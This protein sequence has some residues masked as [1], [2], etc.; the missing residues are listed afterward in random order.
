MPF[1]MADR[2][3][4]QCGL[5]KAG[6]VRVGHKVDVH[7]LNLELATEIGAEAYKIISQ[8]RADQFLGEWLFSVAAFE[9]RSDE[10]DYFAACP[11]LEGT[12]R[13]LGWDFAQLCKLR[14]EVF[15][16]L[17]DRWA[18]K[19]AWRRYKV[20]GFTCTFEQ[21]TPAFALAR[22]IKEKY[23]KIVIVFGGANFDGGM[24]EEYLK[25]L[26]FIDYVVVGEGDVS[27]PELVDRIARGADGLDVPGVIGRVDGK[28]ASGGTSVSV[29]NL[30]GLP[31]PIYDEYFATLFQLGRERVIGNQPPLLLFE[32]ARGCWW[33]EK[34]HCTFC[35]LNAN[36]MQFRSKPP[37]RVRDELRRLSARYKIVNFEAVDNIMDLSYLDQLCEPL[38]EQ[39]SDYQIFY[40]VKANLT[41][42]QLRKLARAGITAIQPGIESLNSHVLNLMRKGT[43]KLINVRLLKWAHYYGI[44]VGWN[45]L[46]GFP[47][48]L[49]EDYEEQVEVLKQIVH[50]PPPAGC[51][52]IWLERFSPY[53]FDPSFQAKNIKP[54]AAYNFIYLESEIDLKKIA[55]FFDHEFEEPRL[56]EQHQKLNDVVCDWKSRWDRGSAPVL[57]YQRAPDWIQVIDRRL[58]Q[59][60]VHAFNCREAFIYDF[61]GETYH[62]VEMIRN[63][64]R[65]ADGDN[66]TT[67]EV[68]SVLER[69]CELGL[70][71]EENGN[72]LSLALP[73]NPNW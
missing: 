8:L 59:P 31:D 30:D 55:Y 9:H 3:S 26:P 32:T 69:F 25:A 44:R 24:G 48:E 62:P 45:I 70:M 21:N 60:A 23:P 68:A 20:V 33:G 73:V 65:E 51:G 12:C 35:G 66:A 63:Q 28:L 19:I 5:L 61:C 16:T 2:P 11:S 49:P 36:G 67:S 53:F 13:E 4:I 27:F 46:T 22:R 58:D 71:L 38:T 56:D 15:P 34:H 39:R 10:A 7:Y 43:N 47:G 72:F 6:L 17:V 42:A 54:K 18:K 41:R 57:V 14:N 40:E 1:A 64:L 50:L 52:P 37:G 29:T